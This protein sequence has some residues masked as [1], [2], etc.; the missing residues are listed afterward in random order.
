[1]FQPK[2]SQLANSRCRYIA[3]CKLNHFDQSSL[4]GDDPLDF[5]VRNPFIEVILS[6]SNFIL[7]PIVPSVY[8]IRLYMYV[9]NI[10]KVRIGTRKNEIGTT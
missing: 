7:V 2:R 9:L 10:Q 1:M 8:S 5:G 3:L 6:C 4:V